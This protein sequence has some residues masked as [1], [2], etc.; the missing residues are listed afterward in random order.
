M[1]SHFLSKDT[2]HLCNSLCSSAPPFFSLTLSSCQ[3]NIMKCFPLKTGGKNS[4][5]PQPSQ[6]TK[7]FICCPLVQHSS[8]VIYSHCF[9][10]LLSNSLT[11]TANCPSTSLNSCQSW[12]TSTCWIQW[13]T[14]SRHLPWPISSHTIDGH[15]FLKNHSSLG[16]QST[17]RGLLLQAA[18]S[19]SSISPHFL[20]FSTVKWPCKWLA[21]F[22]IYSYFSSDH[23]PSTTLNTISILMTPKYWSL[24]QT[25]LKL[26][27]CH[28]QLVI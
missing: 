11:L 18:C 24:Y 7:P 2:H 20:S 22:P 1:C 17:F 14:L 15:F 10:S 6:V 21:N 13:L 23:N 28:I 5:F 25:C 16:F 9:H 26:W 19:F 12:M 4:F 3:S 8:R 27:T